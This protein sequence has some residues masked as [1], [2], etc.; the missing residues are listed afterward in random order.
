MKMNIPNLQRLTQL[1]HSEYHSR[2]VGKLYQV[3]AKLDGLCSHSP[4]W[5]RLYKRGRSIMADA[6]PETR[7][8]YRHFLDSE[9][10]MDNDI[11]GHVNNVGLLFLFRYR[12]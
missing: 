10:W 11:Y 7:A 4:F 8:D 9:R 1:P 2:E 12:D 6:A 3:E 5:S